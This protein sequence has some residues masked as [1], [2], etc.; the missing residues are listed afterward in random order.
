MSPRWDGEAVRPDFGGKGYFPE[1]VSRVAYS[2]DFNEKGHATS[3]FEGCWRGGQEERIVGDIR[4][5]LI[6]WHESYRH[7]PSEIRLLPNG[8]LEMELAGAYY[9]AQVKEERTMQLIWSDGEI[10]ERV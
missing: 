10:W 2:Q 8:E 6:W 9:T 5:G 1:T 4:G 7:R 3:R